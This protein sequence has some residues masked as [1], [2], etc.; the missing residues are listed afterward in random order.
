MRSI[1]VCA[2]LLGSVQAQRLDYNTICH[3]GVGMG[4]GSAAGVIGKNTDQRFFIGLA[5]GFVAGLGK[6]IYDAQK[7]NQAQFQDILATAVGGATS[8]MLSNL[9]IRIDRRRRKSK[10]WL[11]KI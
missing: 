1:I 4:I 5:G 6:E 11:A 3:F 9:A 7:G 2:I 10:S 8:A